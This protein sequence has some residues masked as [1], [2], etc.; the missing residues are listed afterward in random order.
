MK[1]IKDFVL[2]ILIG[3]LLTWGI[4]YLGT[5]LPSIWISF[6][7]GVISYFIGAVFYILFQIILDK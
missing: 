4:I 7:L 1:R 3:N 5:F 6:L 2:I